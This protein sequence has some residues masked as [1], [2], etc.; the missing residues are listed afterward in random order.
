MKPFEILDRDL[1]IHQNY[2]LEA[3][4]GTGK[5]F[6]IE[7]L[8]ARLLIE[9]NPATRLV[10]TIDKILAV[11]FTR[12]AAKDL[13]VRI[14]N[15]LKKALS[16]LEQRQSSE[17]PDYLKSIME[18]GEEAIDAA[19]QRLRQAFYAF[20]EAQIL[21][22]HGFCAQMLRENIFEG[23]I[24]MAAQDG[25][26]SYSDAESSRIVH[27]FFHTGL[28][29]QAYSLEQL[30]ILLKR[31]KKSA[32]KLSESLAKGIKGGSIIPPASLQELYALFKT[33]L[34][35]LKSKYGYTGGKILEDF[36]AQAKVFKKICIGRTAIPK[37]ENQSKAERFAKFFDQE[38]LS[39]DDFNQ[40]IGDGLYLMHAL[41]PAE[42]K[43]KASIPRLHYPELV[44]EISQHLWPIISEAGSY[45]H[46][47]SR[48]LH[49]CQI[50]WKKF[51]QEE[52][53]WG[54]QELLTLARDALRA[55]G[56]AQK[57]WSGYQAV[58]IDEF[59]DTDPI[60]WSLFKSIFGN[61]NA[62]FIYLVGDPK[63]SIYAFRQADI[64]TYLAAAETL[65]P[66]SR[67]SLNT[68][69]R[70]Q[71]P[72][73]EAL[74]FLLAEEHAPGLFPLPRLGKTH[75]YPSVKASASLEAHQFPDA[76][77]P[78][79]FFCAHFKKSVSDKELMQEEQNSLFPYIAHEISRLHPSFPFKEFAV[80]VKDRNQANRLARFLNKWHIPSHLQRTAYLTDSPALKGLQ[81]VMQAVLLPADES[82][83]KIALGSK[84]IGFTQEDIVRLNGSADKM[85]A[86]LF[87]FYH[88]RHVL[89]TQGC[90]LFFHEL[91]SVAFHENGADVAETLLSKAEGLPFYDGLLQIMEL[92]VEFQ[93]QTQANPEKV[94]AFL[95]EFG[96]LDD[97][98]KKSRQDSAQDAVSILTLHMSKGLEFGIVFALGLINRS[99]DHE[100]MIPVPCGEEILLKAVSSEDPLYAQFLEERDAEKMRQL[101]VAMTRAKYRLYLPA[102]FTPN[103][104]A[105]VL[106]TASPMELFLARLDRPA[107]DW[108]TLYSRLETHT[109]AEFFNFLK[110]QNLITF[111]DADAQQLALAPLPRPIMPELAKPPIP[112][113]P[114]CADALYSFSQMA[115]GS[116]INEHANL[117]P[118]HDFRAEVKTVHT[119]PSGKETG[120]FLH[121]ALQ[122][123]PFEKVAQLASPHELIPYLMPIC[124]VSAFKGWEEPISQILFN[125]LRAPLFKDSFQLAQL[126]PH[127]CYREIEF[128]HP[129]AEAAMTGHM[130]GV[131]DFVFIY[132]GKYYLLDWK[133]NWLGP[134]YEA[135]SHEAMKKAMVENQYY[136]QAQIYAKALEKY[137]RIIDSRPFSECFGGIFYL[138][139][140]GIEP[141]ADH[142]HGVFHVAFP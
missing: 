120:V 33:R 128:L 78:I 53:K 16:L 39:L 133:S 72:L 89:M 88:L 141:A 113:I 40:Q 59:Q 110:Q 121:E 47:L 43:V 109:G 135:Y 48:M 34:F 23:N 107:A 46:L 76:L 24:A 4:A 85:A 139:L 117:Q 134:A 28:D 42:L 129:V 6:S 22:I 66:H 123:I 49:D 30:N 100:E 112:A 74:N 15:C 44:P 132:Q 115:A 7:N 19:V 35:E 61:Q 57:I 52:E 84:I 102:L 73:V 3:S 94:L 60:Q 70:S 75:P 38:E 101:Y 45:L 69:Y 18:Q 108:K 5:T 86:A 124:A 31:Q 130:K 114:Q 50:R 8:I 63:Q 79:H 91:L 71:P 83:V 119:L 68:N 99:K 17:A 77:G 36:L 1:P 51:L 140:R 9:E 138:F 54:Y 96:Q 12:A 32:A 62:P 103:G 29:A 20:H 118:P 142:H 41:D 125:G 21:T 131:I 80:L 81:D 14:Q 116:S 92:A 137:L 111:C 2:L 37:P 10:C 13:R 90:A 93:S 95:G 64:Y 67:A 136:L 122:K 127:E 58:I 97:E 11:T 82:Y 65:G 98:Q 55:P 104:K 25:E 126:K 56:F 27:D 26:Q 87:H 105:P 106:G